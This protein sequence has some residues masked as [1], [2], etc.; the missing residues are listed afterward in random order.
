MVG[1]RGRGPRESAKSGN[2]SAKAPRWRVT[3]MSKAWAE[4]PAKGAPGGNRSPAGC[5]RA[6]GLPDCGETFGFYS[7][8][9]GR[10]QGWAGSHGGFRE[11]SA[12]VKPWQQGDPLRGRQRR[13]AGRSKIQLGG[14][15]S[16]VPPP[17]LLEA[18]QP[19]RLFPV[20]RGSGAW[21]RRNSPDKGARGHSRVPVLILWLLFGLALPSP[22]P[23]NWTDGVRA[24][25]WELDL[26]SNPNAPK[27]A[28]PLLWTSASSCKWGGGR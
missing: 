3:R 10:R 20:R 2:G 8:R 24:L 5:E 12:S 11:T 4:K 18:Q 19:L 21:G 7:K 27:R 25:D 28:L 13:K 9:D 23:A 6:S 14:R 1:K 26:E 15:E 17:F 22:R 16:P